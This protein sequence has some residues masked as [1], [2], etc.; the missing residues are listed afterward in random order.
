MIIPDQ[1][2][3]DPEQLARTRPCSV[4]WCA[5][6]RWVGTTRRHRRDVDAY[7]LAWWES[8]LGL[9]PDGAT[10]DLPHGIADK[11]LTEDGAHTVT[12]TLF[13]LLALIDRDRRARER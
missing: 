12:S 5:G 10:I 13:Y 9:D 6:C 1:R 4:T 2:S 11:P 8:D 3:T 7:Q